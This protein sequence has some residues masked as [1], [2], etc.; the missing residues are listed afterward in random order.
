MYHFAWVDQRESRDTYVSDV[1]QKSGIHLDVSW[2]NDPFGLFLILKP[3]S[4]QLTWVNLA[5]F[6]RRN[7]SMWLWVLILI[8][9]VPE[10]IHI[11]CNI[12]SHDLPDMYAFSP[13]GFGHAYQ[14]NPSC[15]CYN[16]YIKHITTQIIYCYK[17]AN[18]D[19]F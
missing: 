13:W 11:T 4:D 1:S 9:R 16:L 17:S 19:I 12:D 5:F 6:N 8:F 7:K 3:Y 15:P 18:Q 14:A 2:E 10:V